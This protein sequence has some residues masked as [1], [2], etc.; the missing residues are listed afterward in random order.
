SHIVTVTPSG[1]TLTYYFAAVWEGE[2]GNGIGTEDEFRKYLQ[3]EAERLTRPVRQR[4]TTRRSLD[5]K[6]QTTSAQS[7]LA[8]SQRLADAELQRKTLGYHADG[9]DVNRRRPPKFEY[10]IVG[11]LPFA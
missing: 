10:D 1:N 8:W 9:W 5:A 4:L 6:T 7:A 3:Q 11:L 2:H